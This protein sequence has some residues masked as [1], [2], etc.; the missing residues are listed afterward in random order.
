VGLFKLSTDQ[1][2][3]M[4]YRGE[5]PLARLTMFS[6]LQHIY[7]QSIKAPEY[8]NEFTLWENPSYALAV[9]VIAYIFPDTTTIF[10]T[11]DPSTALRAQHVAEQWTYGTMDG[12]KSFKDFVLKTLQLQCYFEGNSWT[13]S[14]DEG[15]R[16]KAILNHYYAFGVKPVKHRQYSMLTLRWKRDVQ[17]MV[18]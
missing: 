7:A 13:S 2:K 5:F 18:G 15:I 3:E 1:R 10:S 11:I 12:D 6:Y 16:A 14:N 4:F 8:A 17:K 9:A